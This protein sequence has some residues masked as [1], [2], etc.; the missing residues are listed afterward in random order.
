MGAAPTDFD[1][2]ISLHK[3]EVFCLVIELGGV[4]R[5]ADHLFVSQP[6]VTAHLRS[7]QERLG[8]QL[9][10]RDGRRTE[11]T[12]SGERVYAWASETLARTR[13][14]TR[15]IHGLA[16]GEGGTIILAASM[17]LGSYV[18]PPLLSEFR[19]ARPRAEL[20]LH[21]SDPEGALA[22]VES[23]AC[24]LAVVVAEA[25]PVSRLVSGE[26]LGREPV[27]LVTAPRGVPHQDAVHATALETLPLVASPRTHVRRALVD[28]QLRRAGVVPRNVTIELGHPE[29]MKRATRRGL[30]AA[31]LFRSAVE[32]ELGRGTL[33]EVKIVDAELSVPVFV[34]Q[35]VQKRLTPVQEQF[36]DALR[37]YLRRQLQQGSETQ[38]QPV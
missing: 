27:V 35:R 30:G 14:L 12:E 16:E 34:V 6:V 24:D 15:E 5:A 17:S 13:E 19:R 2:R 37:D 10:R 1:R 21:I 18:L 26:R 31:L 7:L 28:R 4:G 29:A 20:T 3:L 33:R 22:S 11:L 38:P 25:P 9:L 32:E 36:V 8:T 23:G